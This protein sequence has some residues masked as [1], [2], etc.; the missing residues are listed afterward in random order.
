MLN[1]IELLIVTVNPGSSMIDKYHD[2]GLK[3]ENGV[4]EKETNKKH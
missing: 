2:G 1:S 3:V 4:N